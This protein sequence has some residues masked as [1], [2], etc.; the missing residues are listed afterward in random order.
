MKDLKI[1][2]TGKGNVEIIAVT[3][4]AKK[5]FVECGVQEGHC[6][7]GK[8][9]NMNKLL[10]WAISHDLSL[11]TQVPIIIPELP[12]LYREDLV[13]VFPNVPKSFLPRQLFAIG[14]SKFKGDTFD[15]SEQTRNW[16]VN[17][18]FDKGK[19]YPIYDNEG[20]FVVGKDGKGY[21]MTPSAWTKIK[22][23]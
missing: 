23:Y 14:Y 7:S 4:K 10:A 3:D 5:V 16:S 22:E 6:L 20:L 15:K 17:N 8:E 2:S 21:K 19:E 11:D 9:K 13:K 18:Q 12:R 1:N